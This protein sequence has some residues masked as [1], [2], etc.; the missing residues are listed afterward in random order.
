MASLQSYQ[1]QL[2]VWISLPDL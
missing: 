1:T 2:L